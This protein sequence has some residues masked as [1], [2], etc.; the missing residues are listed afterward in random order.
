MVRAVPIGIRNH[1]VVI[2][3]HRI[4][5][6]CEC[7][8]AGARNQ[9]RN[10]H[11]EFVRPTD[12]DDLGVRRNADSGNDHARS[13]STCQYSAIHQYASIKTTT[14]ECRRRTCLK[15]VGFDG[16]LPLKLAQ[17]VFA[18]PLRQCQHLNGLVGG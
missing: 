10:I 15:D 6:R 18:E 9:G 8:R 7:E 3:G 2:G 4:V 13:Q 5:L 11:E 17:Q 1:A 12:G 16:L 14:G